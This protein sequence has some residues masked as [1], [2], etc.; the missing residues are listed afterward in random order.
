[1]ELHVQSFGTRLRTR[2]D[3]FVLYVP[4]LSGEGNEQTYEYAPHQV[5]YFLLYKK[6]GSI[7]AEAL[8]LALKNNVQIL[9]CDE[10]GH[11]IGRFCSLDPSESLSIQAAQFSLIG[12]PRSMAF[13][14]EWIGS[15]FRRK[16]AF[17]ERLEGYREGE[18]RELI[19]HTRRQLT[20]YFHKLQQ[21]TTQNVEKAAAS[22]RGFEGVASRLYF[23]TLSQ[24]LQPE[25]QFEGR[26]RRP[27]HD[28]FN[29]LLNYGY[30]ILQRQVETLLLRNG[31]HPYAG[32]H[33]GLEK[34]QKAMVFDIMEAYRPWIDSVVF[35]LCSRK[36]VTLKHVEE[37]PGGMWLSNEGKSL[38]SKALLNAFDKKPEKGEAQLSQKET[39][40]EEIRTFARQL[41]ASSKGD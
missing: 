14:K 7:S 11:P 18:K 1:M 10:F 5:E 9:L 17:L 3:I 13:V 36:Q 4:D 21:V 22:I 16:M 33:H 41:Q 38:L 24:L 8:E 37:R 20:D 31:I 28:I 30:G 23:S 12:T 26:S 27:A 34:M 6:G 39:L 2:G 15:K 29:A 35:L 19:Q 25:Y 40:K 32:F